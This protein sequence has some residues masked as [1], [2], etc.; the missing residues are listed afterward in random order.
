M[1]FIQLTEA[2]FRSPQMRTHLPRFIL[3]GIIVTTIFSLSCMRAEAQTELA[4]GSF[5][6]GSYNTGQKTLYASSGNRRLGRLFALDSARTLT[7]RGGANYPS[8]GVDNSFDSGVQRFFFSGLSDIRGGDRSLDDN[9]Y[10][11]SFAFG[12]RPNHALRSE[13]EVAFRSNDINQTLM[14]QGFTINS[15]V[16]V[17]GNDLVS[18]EQD[19]RL[20]ATS[21][22]KNF[23]HDFENRTIFTPYI[24]AGIGLS[25]IDIE[26]GKATSTDGGVA[27]QDGLGAFSYQAIGGVATKLNSFSDFIIEYRFL[28]TSEIEFEFL[29][30]TF[31]YNTSTLFLGLTFNF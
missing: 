3:L 4:Q 10:A 12:R 25:Y 2:L 27:L 23:I 28:G 24:G 26:F 13:I 14:R 30:D 21:I 19:G 6:V 29:N 17:Q 22:M 11:V 7:I 18:D 9:G 5:H 15:G 16:V 20:N 31:A 8:E 1:S